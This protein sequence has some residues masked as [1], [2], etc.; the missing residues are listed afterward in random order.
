MLTYTRTHMHTHTRTHT[1]TY[2]HNCHS[3]TCD[4]PSTQLLR[5]PVVMV[6]GSDVPRIVGQF[7][8]YTC[9]PG[10][11]LT[12]PSESICSGNREWEPDP[13]EVDCIGDCDHIDTMQARKL[14]FKEFLS[15]HTY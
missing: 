3:V 2:S 7:I 11:I 13:G 4:H 12:G 1:H 9:Q 5:D 6:T 15:C 8:A 10:F 14:V